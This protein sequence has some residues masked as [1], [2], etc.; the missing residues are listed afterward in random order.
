MEKKA[1]FI[2]GLHSDSGSTTGGIVAE[3]LKEYGYETI[4]PTFDLLDCKGTMRQINEIYTNEIRR[5]GHSG[6]I[7]AHSLGGFYG[8]AFPCE[9]L[10]ILINPCFKPEIVVPK[11]MYDGEVFPE[12]LKQEWPAVRDEEIN[13][14]F[15]TEALAVTHGIFA[16]GDDLFSFAE[17][18]EREL[19]FHHVHRIEGGHKPTKEQLAPAID[20]AINTPV[21]FSP[22]FAIPGVNA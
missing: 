3:I 13:H 19:H 7:A 5:T 8:F 18:A 20:A 22:A 2:H 1:L 6:I 9:A 10:K 12:N 21:Q 4:H 15:D 17:Y 14:Y 16:K 11:L